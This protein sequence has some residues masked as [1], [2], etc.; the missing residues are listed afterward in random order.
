MGKARKPTPFSKHHILS[1]KGTY[2]IWIRLTK[3]LTVRES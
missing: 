1:A 3:E 2:L